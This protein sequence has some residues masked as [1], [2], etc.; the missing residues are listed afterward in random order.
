MFEIIKDFFN[1]FVVND[2]LVDLLG[3]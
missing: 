3:I 1:D 2:N